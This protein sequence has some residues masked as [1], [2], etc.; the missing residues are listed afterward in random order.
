[1]FQI[2]QATIEA[3]K[4]AEEERR[5]GEEKERLLKEQRVKT[6]EE[7]IEENVNQLKVFLRFVYRFA[8]VI[9]VFVGSSCS[10]FLHIS[11]LF[12][13]YKNGVFINVLLL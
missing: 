2:T 7:E 10:Y 1:M 11:Q 13:F 12:L 8:D 3:N 4:R 9:A 5:R 6:N